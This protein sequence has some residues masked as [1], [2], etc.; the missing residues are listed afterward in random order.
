MWKKIQLGIERGRG[1]RNIQL[2][3][4]RRTTEDKMENRFQS[5]FTIGAD[6]EETE[7]LMS[8]SQRCSISK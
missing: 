1:K 8:Q 4:N 6:I 3:F 7:K 5:L 2:A